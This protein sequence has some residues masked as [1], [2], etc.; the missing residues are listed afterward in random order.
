[1]GSAYST[2]NYRGP[3]YTAEQREYLHYHND[4]IGAYFWAAIGGVILLFT[5]ARIGSDF[6]SWRRRRRAAQ[7]V[8]TKQQPKIYIDAHQGEVS[9]SHVPAALTAIFRKISINQPRFIEKLYM[10]RAFA[11]HSQDGLRAAGI[12]RPRRAHR[13]LH[14]AQFRSHLHPRSRRHRLGA[15]TLVVSFAK[16]T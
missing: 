3:E 7:A 13:R 11:S 9:L 5:L 6:Y 14:R 12:D 10:V 2:T 16:L 1:M 8:W 4:R 15:S